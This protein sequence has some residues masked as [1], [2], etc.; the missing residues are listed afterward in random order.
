MIPMIVLVIRYGGM[1]L[2]WVDMSTY[3]EWRLNECYD[4]WGEDEDWIDN[5]EDELLL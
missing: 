4:E 3:E 2:R 5:D 1:V